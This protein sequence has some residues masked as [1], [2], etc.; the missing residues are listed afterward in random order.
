[1]KNQYSTQQLNQNLP[2]VLKQISQGNPIEITH[3]GEPFAVILSSSEY[4]RL[5][6][7]KSSFWESLQDFR[8]SNN[9]EEL[10]TE[11][12]VFAD[13]RDRSIGREVNF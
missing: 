11:T 1:M 6:A 5:T 7:Q 9:L 2:E 12:D 10:E 3:S 4:Q 13:V 8:D